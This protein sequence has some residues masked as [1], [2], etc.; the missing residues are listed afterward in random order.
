MLKFFF[1]VNNYFQYLL[2]L[3]RNFCF[4]DSINFFLSYRVLFVSIYHSYVV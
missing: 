1:Y 2:I 4:I 3:Y